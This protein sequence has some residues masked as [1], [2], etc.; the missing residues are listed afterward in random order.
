MGGRIYNQPE[1]GAVA[2]P[3]PAD[4]PRWASTTENPRRRLLASRNA[5]VYN[6]GAYPPAQLLQV[7]EQ[8]AA[9]SPA[10]NYMNPIMEVLWRWFKG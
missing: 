4:S 2:C 7:M 10:A 5:D 6:P 3:L 1:H 8:Q 9:G